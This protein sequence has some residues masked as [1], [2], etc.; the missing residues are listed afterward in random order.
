MQGFLESLR[1]EVMKKGV[2]VLIAC[3]GFTSSNIR[4][5]ALS[6]DGNPQGESPL[7]ETSIMSAEEV[8]MHIYKAVIKRKRD[9][10]LSQQGKLTVFLNK[11]F[12]TLMDKIV[13][14]HFAKEKD[15][16]LR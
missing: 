5:V 15:S 7:N 16:P 3:P 6:K 8:A 12:P 1:I 9:I 14:N 4:N 2:H 13:F 10:I 11:F